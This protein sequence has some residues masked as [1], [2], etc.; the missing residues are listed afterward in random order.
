MVGTQEK[1]GLSTLRAYC[2]HIGQKIL[3]LTLILCGYQFNNILSTC[4]YLSFKFYMKNCIW[5]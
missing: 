5:A 3:P 4:T 2:S 1:L